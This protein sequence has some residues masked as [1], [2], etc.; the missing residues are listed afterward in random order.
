MPTAESVIE[1]LQGLID[2]ANATTGEADTTLTDA[3]ASLIA[4]FGGGS[5]GTVNIAQGDFTSG[6]TSEKVHKFKLPCPFVPTGLYLVPKTETQNRTGTAT[7]SLLCGKSSAF[8]SYLYSSA[9]KIIKTSV[10]YS[11]SG[12]TLTVKVGTSAEQASVFY[13]SMTY[14]WVAVG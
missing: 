14:A 9:I 12:E 13:N 3:I 8:K 2:T 1:K 11:L 4:G 5:G 6:T 7:V 10:S